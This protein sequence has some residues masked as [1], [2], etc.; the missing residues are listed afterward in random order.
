MRVQH[1]ATKCIFKKSWEFSLNILVDCG[2]ENKLYVEI[3]A[4]S[5]L[6][7]AGFVYKPEHNFSRNRR[8]FCD[9]VTH[10]IAHKMMIEE[11]YEIFTIH[12]LNF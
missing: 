3:L 2:Y 9:C 4:D 12:E 1:S 11:P 7:A 6:I 10:K 8:L 5:F